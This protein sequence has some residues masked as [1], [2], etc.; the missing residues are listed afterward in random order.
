[1]PAYDFRQ[2]TLTLSNSRIGNVII[3]GFGEG[4]DV[5]NVVR[6]DDGIAMTTGAK[7]FVTTSKVANPVGTLSVTLQAQSPSNSILNTLARTKEAFAANITENNTQ[8]LAAG[9][10]MAYVLKEADNPRGKNSGERSWDLKLENLQ[11][12]E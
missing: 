4:D 9:G 8:K 6:D 12:S 1:M 2:V 3:T 10:D 7:G 5:I 11:I